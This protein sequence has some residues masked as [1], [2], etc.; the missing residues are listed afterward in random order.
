M[1][2]DAYQEILL[3]D[4]AFLVL[5]GVLSFGNSL[6]LAD[7]DG[8]RRGRFQ[9]LDW[10]FLKTDFITREVH[11]STVIIY[12]NGNRSDAIKLPVASYVLILWKDAEP[13]IRTEARLRALMS[14]ER[15]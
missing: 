13:Q 1:T 2:A 8:I 7:P 14:T 10:T 15:R 5:T 4:V 3:K 9:K 12:H 11:D 6:E